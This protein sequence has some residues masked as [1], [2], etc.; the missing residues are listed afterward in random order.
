[1]GVGGQR[2]G[3]GWGRGGEDGR[4]KREKE[5]IFEKRVGGAG[6]E[7]GRQPCLC[8]AGMQTQSRPTGRSSGGGGGVVGFL[9]CC[10]LS[11]KQ[12]NT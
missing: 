7:G 3:R 8:C 11:I 5:T 6:G 1:M 4:K 9:S 12:T 2:V 10:L